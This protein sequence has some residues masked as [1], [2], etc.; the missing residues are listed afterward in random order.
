MIPCHFPV[1][2]K[3]ASVSSYRF[4]PVRNSKLRSR[5]HDQCGKSQL[6]AIIGT[7]RPIQA[8]R[9]L[10]PEWPK[11]AYRLSFTPY[12]CNLL[13]TVFNDRTDVAELHTDW[14]DVLGD[15]GE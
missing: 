7:V 8:P 3:C 6:A 1:D 15:R 11:A 12:I 4:Q 14:R 9:L 5:A 10:V 13:C 2:M